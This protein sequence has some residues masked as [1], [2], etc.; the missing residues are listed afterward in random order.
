LESIYLQR[1]E[2]ASKG[3]RNTQMTKKYKGKTDE[4]AKFRL[5]HHRLHDEPDWHVNEPRDV[6]GSVISDQKKFVE[7]KFKEEFTSGNGSGSARKQIMP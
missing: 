7:K 1:L 2:P 4:K 6:M 5:M 3:G